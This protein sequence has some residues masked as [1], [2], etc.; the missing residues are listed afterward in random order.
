M[1][2]RPDALERFVLINQDAVRRA[3]RVIELARPN[4]PDKCTDSEQSH[5]KRDWNKEEDSTH[6]TF[7]P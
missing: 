2:A 3:C 1:A 7:L 4:G 5:E 6:F